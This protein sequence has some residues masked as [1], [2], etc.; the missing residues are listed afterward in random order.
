[1]LLSLAVPCL[2]SAETLTPFKASYSIRW[3]GINAGTGQ[4]ELQE[5]PAGLWA[6]ESRV[7][8]RGVA[9]LFV[10]GNQTSR[11]EFRIVDDK[12]RPMTF[13]SEEHAQKLVFDWDIGRVTGSVNRRPVDLPLQPGLLDQLSVQVAL[14]HELNSG[15]MPVRFTLVDEDRIK[16]YLYAVEGSEV[17]ESVAGTLRADIYSSRRPGSRKATYFWSAPELGNI[18]VKVERRDGRN[19]EWSMRLTELQR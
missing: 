15:R 13:T 14:M 6:Y 8:G 17:I 11:S 16:D 18:P 1:M 9:R 4:L 12:V 5:L 19:V 3:G 7:Q 2:A 10:P